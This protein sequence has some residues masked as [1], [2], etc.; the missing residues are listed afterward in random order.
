M[1]QL[2]SGV[3]SEVVLQLAERLLRQ[4]IEAEADTFIDE[5]RGLTDAR[6]H[7]RVVHNGYLVPRLVQTCVGEI[8]VRQ[9]RVRDLAGNLR[10]QSKIL[11]PYQRRAGGE[12]QLFVYAYHQ[13]VLTG[14]FTE[15]LAALVGSSILC[16]PT[17][18]KTRLKALWRTEYP[19][20]GGSR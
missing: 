3:F 10:F 7:Q 19:T 9:P 18:V 5:H 17:G 2:G 12:N 11:R 8:S 15:A 13:G 1:T 20:V 16:L 14:D 6:G 4:A